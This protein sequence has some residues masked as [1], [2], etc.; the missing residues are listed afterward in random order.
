MLRESRNFLPLPVSLGENA[1]IQI[2]TLVGIQQFVPF[3]ILECHRAAF[4]G[5]RLSVCPLDDSY[6]F[7]PFIFDYEIEGSNVARNS[8]FRIIR[9]YSLFLHNLLCIFRYGWRT[10][11]GQRRRNN[12]YVCFFHFSL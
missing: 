4:D 3:R 1:E 9:L 5:N 12:I 8:N 11:Y 6:E 2:T 10:G 7:V